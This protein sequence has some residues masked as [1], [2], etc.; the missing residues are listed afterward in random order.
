MIVIKNVFGGTKVYIKSIYNDVETVIVYNGGDPISVSGGGGGVTDHGALTGLA[1]DDHSQYH[2]DARGDAR[3][4][5]LKGADDNYVTDAEKIVI[6]NTSGTNTG[7]QDLSGKQD[8]LVSGTNIKT[9]NSSSVLGSGD[10][11]VGQSIYDI[12][13]E[14]INALGAGIKAQTFPVAFTTTI[15]RACLDNRIDFYPVYLPVAATLTGVKWLQAA[16]GSYTGDNYNG[17]G[18]YS[19]SGGTLTLVASST[20]D[21]EIWKGTAN[22]TQTKAFSTP[23]AAAA[24]VYYVA[25]LYCQSAQTTQPTIYAKSVNPSQLSELLTNSA[26]FYGFVSSATSLPASIESS[27]IT[28][29]AACGWVGII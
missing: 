11:V 18:L 29:V 14:L 21:S 26:K 8:T 9:I 28:N 5:P 3:Y 24:G 13:L 17:F 12:D 23:Y 25:W 7:D 27:S 4:E 1:D 2:N 20:N 6:G 15:T 22:T 19:Y 10:L 16:Q